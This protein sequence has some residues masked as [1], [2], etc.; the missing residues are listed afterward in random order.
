MPGAN[1]SLQTF[2]TQY[3][4]PD[5]PTPEIAS[6]QSKLEELHEVLEEIIDKRIESGKINDP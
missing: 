6:K 4:K 5:D 1:Q 2:Q 3:S